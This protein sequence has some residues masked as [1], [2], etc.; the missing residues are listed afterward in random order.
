MQEIAVIGS[1]P[2]G[3]MAADVLVHAG[4]RVRL[5][6]KRNGIA[7]K[8]FVAGS[9]G[10]NISNNLDSGA[11]SAQYH[12]SNAAVDAANKNFAT[13]KWLSFVEDLGLETFEGTS[14]RYFVKPMN[15][16]KLVRAWR[17]RLGDAGVEFVLS[18]ECTGLELID[19]KVRLNFSVNSD[20]QS[21]VPV[22]PS[23][24]ARRGSPTRYRAG[25]DGGDERIFDAV[26][27]A[28][29]GASYEPDETPLRWPRIFSKHGIHL[30]AFEASNVGFH[31]AWSEDFLREA[32]GLALK[33]INFSSARGSKLG[34]LV[35]TKYGLE[36]TPVYTYGC[37]GHIYLDLKPDMNIAQMHARCNAIK[38]N[39]S[40]IRRVKKQLKLSPAALALIHHHAPRAALESLDGL[41]TCIKQFPL[42]LKSPQDLEEAISS[43]GGIAL[44][45]IDEG[46]M[47]RKLP[48]VFCAGEMLAWDAP[49]GGFLIQGSVAQGYA[50]AKAILDFI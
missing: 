40:P 47:L 33:N 26:C 17:K 28:L 10:L 39:L 19:S 7:R 5:F 9:S 16:L 20:L 13:K 43:R 49:T 38:E 23:A 35:I 48:G 25:D 12:P 11:F 42:E 29:G 44:E 18:A 24:I 31:V 34:D 41:L 30:E 1:G 14:G 15:G 2:A 6:E 4:C 21:A 8:L 3:L 50:A 37:T 32:E 45:E 27:F 22:I 36:G 46:F